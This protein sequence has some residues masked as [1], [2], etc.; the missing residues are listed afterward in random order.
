[1]ISTRDFNKKINEQLEKLESLDDKEK[2]EQIELFL[3]DYTASKLKELGVKVKKS[4]FS[5]LY[6]LHKLSDALKNDKERSEIF[7]NYT[8]VLLNMLGKLQNSGILFENKTY[9]KLDGV[10]VSTIDDNL[11]ISSIKS[12]QSCK[13]VNNTIYVHKILMKEMRK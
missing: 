13:P 10:P 8:Y 11:N 2:A 5:L 7:A 1:M 6:L 4:E 9:D 12:D 3:I